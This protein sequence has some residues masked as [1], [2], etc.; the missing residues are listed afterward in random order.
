LTCR[1]SQKRHQDQRLIRVLRNWPV[2]WSRNR[3]PLSSRPAARSP[4]FA[5]VWEIT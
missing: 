1:P 5:Q 4:R 3:R 2:N